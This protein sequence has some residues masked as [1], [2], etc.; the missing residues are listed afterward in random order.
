[1][2][3]KHTCQQ[4][5]KQILEKRM[6]STE[7]IL[8]F[9]S[10]RR[11]GLC[12]TERFTL[13]RNYR[14]SGDWRLLDCQVGIMRVV[15]LWKCVLS[16]NLHVLKPSVSF[17]FFFFFCKFACFFPRFCE[18]QTTFARMCFENVF[19]LVQLDCVYRPDDRFQCDRHLFLLPTSTVSVHRVH[20]RFLVQQR[21]VSSLATVQKSK[22]PQ[23]RTDKSDNGRNKRFSR[24]CNLEISDT[25]VA[26]ACLGHYWAARSLLFV[27]VPVW[28]IFWAARLKRVALW[29]HKHVVVDPTP[30]QSSFMLEGRGKLAQIWKCDRTAFA[31]MQ[32]THIFL[33]QDRAASHATEWSVVHSSGTVQQSSETLF[34]CQT[35][36]ISTKIRARTH[37]VCEYLSGKSAISLRKC[38]SR[39]CFS[40]PDP[41]EESPILCLG[42]KSDCAADILRKQSWHLQNP[43]NHGEQKV[44]LDIF[45]SCEFCGPSSWQDELAVNLTGFPRD[46]IEKIGVHLTNFIRDEKTAKLSCASRFG[47]LRPGLS[48]SISQLLHDSITEVWASIP[49]KHKEELTRFDTR[50][51]SQAEDLWDELDGRI[52]SATFLSACGT[53]VMQN[54]A[55]TCLFFAWLMSWRLHAFLH[56]R[57][58]QECVAMFTK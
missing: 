42:Y 22:G 8:C 46:E 13:W 39:C 34:D 40:M 35:F 4:K 36:H 20:R 31:L 52:V 2:K 11:R 26:C 17:F 10:A 32:R 16:L 25:N 1:M 48:V 19:V 9:L 49:A 38:D 43:H 37:A 44:G 50:V 3:E 47:K 6:R 55:Q 5:L 45:T 54:I 58:K 53:T 21:P 27:L 7:I 18:Q 33:L 30:C 57:Q 51:C 56:K 15:F 24:N 28:D 23:V 12:G 41:S 29:S 14:T